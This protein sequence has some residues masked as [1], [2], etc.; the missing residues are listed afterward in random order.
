M[1][2]IIKNLANWFIWIMI[3]PLL[4]FIFSIV[5]RFSYLKCVHDAA[6]AVFFAIWMFVISIIYIANSD[7]DELKFFK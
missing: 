5:F 1:T 2:S 4:T 6:Y 7:D 3:C